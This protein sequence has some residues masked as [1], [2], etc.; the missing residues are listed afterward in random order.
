MI[1]PDAVKV[2]RALRGMDGIKAAVVF[3]SAARMEDFVEGLSDIDVLVLLERR[4]PK[5]ERV[6]REKA[7]ALGISPAIMTMREF[8]RGLRAGDPGLLLMCRGRPLWR[9]DCFESLKKEARVTPFTLK[10][11]LQL[12]RC[13]LSISLR[14]L[15]SNPPQALSSA[16]HAARHA[17]RARILKTKKVLMD[18]NEEIRLALPEKEREEFESFLEARRRYATIERKE[19]KSLIRLARRIIDRES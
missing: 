11:L 8:A 13:A 3:G 14:E 2:G 19:L 12:A 5:V 10:R 15:D 6:I 9:S 4:N 17:L 16:Y 7:A 1:H 18:S